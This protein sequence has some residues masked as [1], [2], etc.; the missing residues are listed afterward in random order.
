MKFLNGLIWAILIAIFAFGLVEAVQ[1][2][3]LDQIK[4]NT[5]EHP[6][7]TVAGLFLFNEG[8]NGV[9][10]AYRYNISESVPV[11]GGRYTFM[12]NDIPLPDGIDMLIVIPALVAWFGILKML[13]RKLTF[14]AWLLIMIF[15]TPFFLLFMW[16]VAKFLWYALFIIGSKMLGMTFAEA[17]AVR[18]KTVVELADMIYVLAIAAFFS[19]AA[20]AKII[21]EAIWGNKD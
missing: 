8:L 4:N 10:P 7:R 13:K 2:V 15:G 3:G 1:T 9:T 18:E 6:E 14:G 20:M 12:L 19:V 5:E 16:I 11:I 21:Y 17:Q